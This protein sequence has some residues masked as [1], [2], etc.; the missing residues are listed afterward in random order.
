EIVKFLIGRGTD[1]N[2]ECP[3]FGDALQI[4][5]RETDKEMINL[6]LDSGANINAHRPGVCCTALQ[7]A[8]SIPPL[9]GVISVLELLL[10][11]GADINAIG[12]NRG[13]AL[14]TAAR[15]GINGEEHVRILLRRGAFANLHGGPQARYVTPLH[16]AIVCRLGPPGSGA[17]Y[18][19]E[20]VVRMLVDAGARV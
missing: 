18:G 14:A 3:F 11:R 20:P 6:L 19:H 10:D 12:G 16:A 9:P 7:T 13:T 1:I 8:A 4:S 17:G 15:L 2:A 5:I